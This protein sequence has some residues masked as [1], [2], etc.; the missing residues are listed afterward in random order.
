MAS[1][2]SNTASAHSRRIGLASALK[3]DAVVTGVNGGAYLLAAQPLG[4]L[5]GLS[6]ALLRL[7]GIALIAFAAALW[8][9]AARPSVSRAVAVALGGAN[10]AWALARIAVAVGGW[11]SPTTVGTLWI[12]AQAIVVAAF[13]ELQVTA[14]KR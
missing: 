9:A 13:A 10:A 2:A 7:L 8:L 5:L 14:L 4:D 6:P 1:L 3:L 12:I 11:L